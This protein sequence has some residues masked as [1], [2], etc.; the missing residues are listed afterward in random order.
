M[1]LDYRCFIKF[2]DSLHLKEGLKKIEIGACDEN[3]YS[4]YEISKVFSDPK[5]M[6][7]MIE[8]PIGDIFDTVAT[9]EKIGFCFVHDH[10][11]SFSFFKELTAYFYETLTNQI[12]SDFIIVADITDYDDDSFGNHI[13]Y[14]LG[15]NN[16]IKKIVVEGLEGLMLHNET[17]ISE[18][19]K[20][21]K[22]YPISD[23]EKE[24]ADKF[25]VKLNDLMCYG[26]GL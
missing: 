9:D 20:I 4:L 22:E 2:K 6:M 5:Q 7:R 18:M 16:E 3:V 21:L 14:Y 13:F 24:N 17:E 12:G 10:K 1:H 15:A 25:Y 26:L 19:V 8:E 11:K 23:N